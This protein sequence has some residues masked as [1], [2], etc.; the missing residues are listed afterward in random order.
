MPHEIHLKLDEMPLMEGIGHIVAQRP[1]VHSDR[2][3]SHH[4]FNYVK[5]GALHIGEDET[6]YT[7]RPGEF[8]F[9]ES[10]ARQW[11]PRPI[12]AGT[13][14][15][16]LHFFL[17]SDA[18]GYREFDGYEAIR[19]QRFDR[20]DYRLYLTLPKYGALHRRAFFEK[21][22]H[23]LLA[24]Y[25]SPDPFR[26]ARSGAA[27]QS[28]L[29][30]FCHASYGRG[31]KADT[32]TQKLIAYL[33]ANSKRPVT[34]EEIA[35]YMNMNY[36]YLCGL[37]RKKT[38]LSIQ[39]Y[40]T[41]LRIHEA[42]RLMLEAPVNISEAGYAVGFRDPLYFS[43]VFKK[44]RGVSPTEFLLSTYKGSAARTQL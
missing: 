37:F 31:E 3:I 44:V 17:C 15:Y 4:V 6:E 41:R 43:H 28:F 24:L 27:L 11:G 30:E 14:W 2:V 39:A 13:E 5:R 29:V 22:L 23:Q 20:A 7:V 40:H 38:G 1:F 25:D 12:E 36:K 32:P 33:E 16:Y 35:A 34:S 18:E 19:R 10:G 8:L 42:M 9:L 21:E 26:M